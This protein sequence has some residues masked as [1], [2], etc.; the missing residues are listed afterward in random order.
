[1]IYDNKT[2][3][4]LS[5]DQLKFHENKLIDELKKNTEYWLGT[6]NDNDAWAYNVS[7]TVEC[8]KQVRKFISASNHF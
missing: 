5:I 1:M 3:E 2:L 8:L 4:K 7:S 6:Y